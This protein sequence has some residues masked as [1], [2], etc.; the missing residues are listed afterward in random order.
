MAPD[1]FDLDADD[2]VQVLDAAPPDARHAEIAEA[3][4][5]CPTRAIWIER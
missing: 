4:R 1:V 5:A 2:K 3:V